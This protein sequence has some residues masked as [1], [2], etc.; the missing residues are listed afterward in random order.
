MGEQKNKV[1]NIIQRSK[2]TRSNIHGTEQRPR[3]SVSISNK[4]V[5]AQIINDDT[6]TTLAHVTTVN[7]KHVGTMIEKSKLI[8][9]EI[10]KKAK[11]KKINKVSFDRGAK[12]YHGRIKSLADSARENGLEF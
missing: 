4:H 12:Q 3:L 11:A 5:S 1:K 8:G 6:G 2:R 7:S 9:V 10:A